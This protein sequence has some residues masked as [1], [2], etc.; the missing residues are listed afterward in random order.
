MVMKNKAKYSLLVKGMLTEKVNRGQIQRMT[1]DT[2][3]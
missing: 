2:A 3:L 1:T